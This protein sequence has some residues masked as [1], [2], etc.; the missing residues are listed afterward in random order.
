MN[1]EKQA[2]PRPVDLPDGCTI[3]NVPILLHDMTTLLVSTIGEG[4]RLKAQ[5]DLYKKEKDALFAQLLPQP[6]DESGYLT[7]HE[8]R[9]TEA[10]DWLFCMEFVSHSGKSGK[11]TALKAR[12]A[13]K[14]WLS[15]SEADRLKALYDF[16]I[17]AHKKN[18]QSKWMGYNEIPFLP[19]NPQRRTTPNGLNVEVL[20]AKAFNSCP[21]DQW[22]YIKTFLQWQV[23]QE[24]PFNLSQDNSIEQIFRYG[25]G[26]NAER[27]NRWLR[28]LQRF[29]QQ[30]LIPLGAAKTAFDSKG[31]HWFA[32]TPVG[33]YILGATDQFA[34]QTKEIEGDIIVQ[35]NFEIVF[36]AANPFAEGELTRYAERIG[37]GLGT[38]FRITRTSVHIAL[39]SGMESRQILESLEPLSSKKLPANVIAQ[40]TDW[41]NSFRRVSLKKITV[42]N[43]P[44]SATALRIHALFPKKT[45][46]I[47][48]T[49][50]EMH[51][52]V[53]DLTALKTKLKKNGIG[54][55]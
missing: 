10:H 20:A 55:D 9:L 28:V 31:N 5:G 30:R 39:N 34:Y 29:L 2:P 49:L 6:P 16:M 4:I 15:G 25:N 13:G 24:N 43:C 3:F 50:L 7:A 36:T 22:M 44:D 52:N 48:D 1:R 54:I 40:I 32:I 8:G 35:P 12:Q 41:G 17:K 45:N 42:I 47:T 26:S 37:H 14:E 21:V 23:E 46:L 18:K 27:E 53:K 11:S 19:D 33:S 38:L 51:N